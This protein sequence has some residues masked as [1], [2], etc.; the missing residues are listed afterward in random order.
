MKNLINYLVLLCTS[1]IL[2]DSCQCNKPADE[3]ECPTCEIEGQYC[4]N[5]ICRCPDGEELIGA[6]CQEIDRTDTNKFYW[7]STIT[8]GNCLDSVLCYWLIHTSRMDSGITSRS[9]QAK[10]HPQTAHLVFANAQ[11]QI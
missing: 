7:T 1:L 4:E 5:Y 11:S 2:L 6:Y 8:N 3:E 9:L 10:T